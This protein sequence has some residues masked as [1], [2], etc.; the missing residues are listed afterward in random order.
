MSNPTMQSR[1][2][3]PA[4]PCWDQIWLLTVKYSCVHAVKQQQ[5]AREDAV[6]IGENNNPFRT[7]DF[8]TFGRLVFMA[9]YFGCTSPFLAGQRM[10]GPRGFI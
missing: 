8:S 5:E 6:E 2:F 4:T 3:L 1:S 10:T 9:K 7:S